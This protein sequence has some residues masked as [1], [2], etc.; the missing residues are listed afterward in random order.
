MLRYPVNALPKKILANATQN[1]AEPPPPP[2]SR[3]HC[4][5]TRHPA[6]PPIRTD[7]RPGGTLVLG[8]AKWLVFSMVGGHYAKAAET[9]LRKDSYLLTGSGDMHNRFEKLYRRMVK[10]D[11]VSTKFEASDFEG[12]PAKNPAMLCIYQSLCHEG[13]V[14]FEVAGRKQAPAIAEVS[15]YHVH[16][17][18]PLE[19]MLADDDA[20]RYRKQNRLSRPEFKEQINDVANLTFISVPANQEIK[21][22]PPYD[23]LAKLTTPKN[24]EA[25]CIPKDPELWRPENFDKFCEE[26]RRLLSKAM[27]SYIHSLTE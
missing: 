3:P 12:L 6:H 1:I 13:A 11:L 22:R 21:K 9:A 5:P 25:H 20:E 10:D 26:R 27:N 23:Y 17:I 18:F 2:G 15:N 24:L 4:A 16:H 19:F 14:D 8:L 7:R